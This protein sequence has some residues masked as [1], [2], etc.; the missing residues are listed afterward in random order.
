MNWRLKVLLSIND[1]NGL[2]LTTMMNTKTNTRRMVVPT[3]SVFGIAMSLATAFV[4]ATETVTPSA[5]PPTERP[6]V[7][8]MKEPD[9]VVLLVV[10]GQEITARNYAEALQRSANLGGP[11]SDSS[12]ARK[13]VIR[14]MVAGLLLKEDLRKKGLLNEKQSQAEQSEV[15][16]KF[17]AE[18]FPLPKEIDESAAFKYYEDHKSDFGIPE[19]MRISQ[20]QF[21]VPEGAQDTVKAEVKAKTEATLKRLEGGEPFS[22]LAGELTEN[23]LG[24]LPQGDLGFLNVNT[25]EWLKKNLAGLKAGQHTGVVESPSGY[26]ILMITDVR[27]ALITPY[28]NARDKVIQRAKVL[29]QQRLRDIYIGGLA[30]QAKIEIKDTDLAKLFAKGI[31]D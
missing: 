26:E 22:R 3:R 12:E 11:V 20:I 29:E 21:V 15:L 28:P 4:M 23:P 5:N 18:H 6:A 1:M 24:K 9:R 17:A 30:K 7:A 31:F 10:N 13:A 8:A 19:M 27:P 16:K 2:T 25:N 14:Q